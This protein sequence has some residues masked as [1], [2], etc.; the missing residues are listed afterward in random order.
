MVKN[1]FV[2][3]HEGTTGLRIV[4]RL[5]TRKDIILIDIDDEDR[6]NMN[7]IAHKVK[8]AHIVFL[9]LPD[10]ASKEVVEATA[11]GTAKFID[12]S[13]A[14]RTL[15]HW[16]YGF[17]ELSEEHCKRIATNQYVA[18]P[19]CHASGMIAMVYPLVQAG[20]MPPDY[21]LAMTSLTGYSGGGKK[22]ISQYE[23]DDRDV[24]LSAPR[25]Y[26]LGQSHKH[27]KEVTHVCQLSHM[28]LFSPIVD[29]YYAGMEVILPIHTNLLKGN[30][31]AKDIWNVLHEQYKNASMI[32]VMPFNL[33][34]DNGLFLSAGLQAGLDD[35]I[36]YV[37]GNDERVMVHALFDNLG[38][39]A[40]GAAI[41]CM[42]IMLGV[43]E[44]TGL[45]LGNK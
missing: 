38:K 2:V 11:G 42:N 44:T 30:P 32:H 35:M 17:P 9:C 43:P 18:V 25:Q 27:L 45:M 29:D 39:G 21:P 6:K 40:S 41:Q 24:L 23:S 31:T 26:G 34:E 16:A 22:M 15:S 4:E 14:H 33:E 28:P 8:D 37:T 7:V 1:V 13:T 5:R 36:I 20:L 10:A 3:G 19:G 12:A